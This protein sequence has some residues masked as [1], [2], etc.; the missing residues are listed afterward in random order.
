MRERSLCFMMNKNYFS[1]LM[2]SM[3]HIYRTEFDL[4][5]AKSL[6][7][8]INC[9]FP[10]PIRSLLVGIH[11]GF[12]SFLSTL[13]AWVFEVSIVTVMIH[14]VITEILFLEMPLHSFVCLLDI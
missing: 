5:A 1:N 3:Q 14:S 7:S 10:S 8:A 4:Q 11:S 2:V 9:F 6:S 12:L 13:H